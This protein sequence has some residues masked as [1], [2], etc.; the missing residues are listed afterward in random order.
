MSALPSLAPTAPDDKGAVH[1]AIGD[2]MALAATY[3]DTAAQ[4]AAIR[5]VR[6]LA[7][8]IRSASACVLNAASLLDELRPSQR[9]G[10][11][12]S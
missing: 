10:G 8:A 7:Y 6:G 2:A 1:G 9:Q 3:S 5:D 4:Y 11:R 12:A